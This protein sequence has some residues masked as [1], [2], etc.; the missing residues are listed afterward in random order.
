MLRSEVGRHSTIWLVRMT[1]DKWRAKDAPKARECIIP[2]SLKTANGNATIIEL[3]SAPFWGNTNLIEYIISLKFT[4]HVLL[5]IRRWFHAM[6]LDC[7]VCWWFAMV[8]SLSPFWILPHW[9]FGDRPGLLLLGGVP[10]LG[11]LGCIIIPS[12]APP[13][14]LPQQ[15]LK[16][17]PWWQDSKRWRL[18]TDDWRMMLVFNLIT[19]F[20]YSMNETKE[21]G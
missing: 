12:R 21:L 8:S 10:D 19:L 18:S 13:A 15:M 5:A 11:W 20:G 9:P 14:A 7:K 16:D 17:C 1:R 6:I 3:P 2:N 4:L